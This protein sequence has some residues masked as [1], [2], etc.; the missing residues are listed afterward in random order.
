MASPKFWRVLVKRAQKAH[1]TWFVPE[2]GS[3]SIAVCGKSLPQD[4][5][6]GTAETVLDPHGDECHT[7]LLLAGYKVERKR[8]GPRGKEQPG[9]EALRLKALIKLG[10][11]VGR[12]PINDEGKRAMIEAIVK[13]L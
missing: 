8:R 13:A 3:G 2:Q 9:P 5:R 10:N 4:E 6:R 1:L 7:C 12:L 11:R